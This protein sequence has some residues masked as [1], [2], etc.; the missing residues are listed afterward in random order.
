ENT[1]HRPDIH[2]PKQAGASMA[3]MI[4][5][6]SP[7]ADRWETMWHYMQ[8]GPGIFA[9]DL[10]YYFSDGDLRDGKALA[11]RDGP[12]P[13][14]LLSGEYDVSATP[15]MGRELAQLIGAEHFEVMHHVGHFPMSENPAAFRAYI[16]PVLSKIANGTD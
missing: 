8:G 5:P 10:H 7:A 1:L 11:L 15:E 16:L 4:A 14:Y 12:C 3:G 6:H 2:G 9:G 13:I